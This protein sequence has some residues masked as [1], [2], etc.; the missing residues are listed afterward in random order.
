MNKILG[1][2]KVPYRKLRQNLHLRVEVLIRFVF[3]IVCV[4]AGPVIIIGC[5]NQLKMHYRSEK[6]CKNVVLGK[7]LTSFRV[8]TEL[9]QVVQV[10]S[11][12]VR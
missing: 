10:V 4:Q 5:C 2:Q 6:N 3:L 11:Q 1:Y 7:S 8:D 12:L 9:I